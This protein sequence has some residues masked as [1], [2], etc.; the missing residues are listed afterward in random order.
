MWE[1]RVE[2]RPPYNFDRVIERL[3]LDPLINLDEKERTVKVPFYFNQEPIVVTVKAI[4]TTDLP[5]FL[6]SGE[7][8][9]A[10]EYALQRVTHIFQWNV[11]LEEIQTHF[12]PTDLRAIFLEHR[13]TP[14]VL[15]FDPYLSL[16]KCIIHQ[17]VNMSFAF[18][19]TA[20]FVKTFGK[21]ID[22]TWIYP[23]PEVIS[24]IAIQDL[25]ELQF[26]GRK[27]EY[28]IDTSK[29]IVEGS[30]ELFELY[31]KSDEEITETLVKIRGIGHWTAQN[32]LLFALGRQNLFPMADIGIQN[33]IKKLYK[34]EKKPTYEQMEAYSRLW[35][36]YLSYASLYLWRSI[37]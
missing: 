1:K 22:G 21:E 5:V 20:R 17:Q 3:S 29:L 34:L 15:D 26:S 18:T 25:R 7:V 36:P 35:E 2:V 16:M 6:V 24:K 12:L 27:A 19:L 23:T 14:L 9:D 31:K 33:A 10:M 8:D 37:E 13:G 4:G 30:L 28:V 11:P 32:F